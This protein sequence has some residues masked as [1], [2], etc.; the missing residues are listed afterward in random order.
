MP[1]VGQSQKFSTKRSA[2]SKKDEAMRR[3]SISYSAK[4][5]VLWNDG[6]PKVRIV[7]DFCA[8]GKRLQSGVGHHA[9]EVGHELLL[10]AMRF[11]EKY[12]E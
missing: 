1:S 4:L 9:D 3:L 7:V 12:G 10:H 6:T 8:I 11:F 2:G 5:T